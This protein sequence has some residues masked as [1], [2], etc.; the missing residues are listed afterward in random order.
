MRREF[1]EGLAKVAAANKDTE[2]R[3]QNS[4]AQIAATMAASQNHG[5]DH[6]IPTLPSTNVG[7]AIAVFPSATTA[8]VAA[9][10]PS[11]SAT[12]PT[13]RAGYSEPSP[14][15]GPPPGPIAGLA[16]VTTSAQQTPDQARARTP[17][18]AH[19]SCSD[20]Q[21][22][23]S[24]A[25]AQQV[26][27]PQGFITSIAEVS[28]PGHPQGSIG[29]AAPL[30]GGGDLTAFK[31]RIVAIEAR[32]ASHLESTSAVHKKLEILEG[33]FNEAVQNFAPVA[34]TNR[35]K[36][37]TEGLNARL[38]RLEKRNSGSGDGPIGKLSNS[39][40]MD[41]FEHYRK[42]FEFV[43]RVLP[44]EEKQAMNFFLKAKNEA[45]QSGH[46]PAQM[47][48]APAE[49]LGDEVSLRLLMTK[50]EEELHKAKVDLH[51]ELGNLQTVIQ[52]V[53]RDSKNSVE[54]AQD[55]MGRISRMEQQGDRSFSDLVRQ[56]AVTPPAESLTQPP[57]LGTDPMT[58]DVKCVDY[59]AILPPRAESA[60]QAESKGQGPSQGQDQ[61]RPGTPYALVSK[62]GLQQAI[63]GLK[64]DMRHWLDVLHASIVTALQQKADSVALAAIAQQVQS[65][66][67]LT[68]E[69]I[70]AFARRALIG[71]C[72]S[73]D[74]PL[75][76]EALSWKNPGLL[77]GQGKFPE[78][79]SS[80]A[81]VSTRPPG[82]PNVHAVAPSKLP[83]LTDIRVAKDFPKGRVIKSGSDPA[84]R[85]NRRDFPPVSV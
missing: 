66:A 17:P 67:G 85:G 50:L 33:A 54:T 28:S 52:A 4:V 12:P 15:L 30:V 22:A 20:R 3:L 29:G 14:A 8:E 37:D 59:M 1:H 44:E 78:R 55:V 38:T 73:C 9:S 68:N 62:R 53:Q 51:H 34:D 58:L 6:R 57:K 40:I 81:Q 21:E 46:G 35:L 10:L 31:D 82:P 25:G 60:G 83:K 2:D 36:Q 70:A 76:A 64:E 39:Q 23:P 79:V 65:A 11:R 7:P 19:T 80:G 32:E 16:P 74:T 5:I 61:E 71:R 47:E 43:R 77:S 27:Q 24:F 41:Q 56:E 69:N 49:V 75:S 72:A 18:Q 48:G 84:L 26:A 42:L 63:T 13:T 45:S